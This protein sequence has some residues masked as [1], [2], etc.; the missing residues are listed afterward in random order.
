MSAMSQFFGGGVGGGGGSVGLGQATLFPGVNLATVSLADELYVRSGYYVS[1]AMADPKASEISFLKTYVTT[2]PKAPPAAAQGWRSLAKGGNTIVA[3]PA[4]YNGQ[5]YYSNDGGNTWTS[6]TGHADNAMYVAYSGQNFILITT[7]YTVMKIY[8]SANGASWTLVTTITT[9]A[10]T[11]RM[12]SAGNG[13]LIA[14]TPTR[15]AVSNDHGVTWAS[16]SGLGGSLGDAA[17]V[18][19]N[20]VMWGTQ[21]GVTNVYYTVSRT[22]AAN[23]YRT[24]PFSGSVTFSGA[25]NNV[26]DLL[27]FSNTGLWKTADGLNWTL[28]NGTVN[29][30]GGEAL[31]IGAKTLFYN[32][33][34]KTLYVYDGLT[35]GHSWLVIPDSVV[36]GGY[37]LMQ[38]DAAT[39]SIICYNGASGNTVPFALR[40]LN[41]NAAPAGIGYP[42]A[43]QAYGTNQNYYW[44]VR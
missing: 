25:S 38:D 26:D 11:S 20:W 5:T 33:Q 32:R 41:I 13:A 36:V 44:R 15:I 18:G 3:L 4:N 37:T 10:A 14:W 8:K 6:V 35:F 2:D 22:T 21:S 31:R 19:S 23:T 34:G 7:D 40:R 39:G 29:S 16:Q 27:I 42:E 17:L 30:N 43:I 24:G 9:N 28:V 1:T 12:V